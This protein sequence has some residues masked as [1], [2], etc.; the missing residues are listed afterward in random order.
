MKNRIFAFV[1]VLALTL[2]VGCH[3]QIPS[4][5]G[6]TSC[7][8]AVPNGNTYAPLNQSTPASGLSY[9]D[10][11]GAGNWCYIAQSVK[12]AN[13]SDPS[14]TTAPLLFT[15]AN[16]SVGLS[17]SAPTSGPVPTGYVISRAPAVVQTLG[18]PNLQTPVVAAVDKPKNTELALAA[19]TG[20][21]A[22]VR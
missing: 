21:T 20:F 18:A 10:N 11:P 2:S 14:N 3:A 8:V 17:W 16:H 4:N 15:A 6:V 7:P 12:G 13:S 19:P 5:P 9:S 22:K 1:A